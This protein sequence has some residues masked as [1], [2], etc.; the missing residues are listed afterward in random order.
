MKLNLYPPEKFIFL[1]LILLNLLLVS[2]GL[3]AQTINVPNFIPQTPEGKW[4]DRFGE[5][6]V[7]EYTGIPSIT[8][9]LHSVKLKDKDFSISLDYHAG[10]IKVTDE[11]SWVG[12]G[13]NIS[14]LGTISVE[15]VGGPDNV[16][17]FSTK[18][19]KQVA[20]DH[21]ISAGGHPRRFMGTYHVMNADGCLYDET[22]PVPNRNVIND[23]LN[24]N[25]ER[26]IYHV[27]VLGNAFKFSID[28]NTNEIIPVGEKTKFK[29]EKI[30][31]GWKMVDDV[32]YEYFFNANEYFRYNSNFNQLVNTW[33][34]TNIV[35]QG[36]ELLKTVHVS[37]SLQLLPQISDVLTKKEGSI[38]SIVRQTTYV[39]EFNAKYPKYIVTPLDSIVFIT[40][41][42]IDLRNG[43]A[44]K[45][46]RVYNRLNK[47]LIKEVDFQKSYFNGSAD[48]TDLS[49]LDYVIKRLKLDKIVVKGV[50]TE[51]KVHTFSYYDNLPYKNSFSQDFWGYYNGENNTFSGTISGIAT[52]AIHSSNRTLLPTPA[53]LLFEEDVPNTL[54]NYRAANRGVNSN[55]VKG[56]SLKNIIY[57]T[58]GSTEFDYEPN[59]VNNVT[60]VK[61]S[62]PVLQNVLTT[63][64]NNGNSTFSTPSTTFTLTKEVKGRIKVTLI[65]QTLPITN[66]ENFA[67]I[68]VTKANTSSPIIKKY[69]IMTDAQKQQFNNTKSVTIEEDVVLPPGLV[70]LSATNPGFPDQGY[71]MPNG[72]V[73]ELT[74]FNI[75]DTD[76]EYDSYVG[77]L[78]IKTLKNYGHDATILN[79]KSFEYLNEDQSSSGKLINPIRFSY[80]QNTRFQIL[81]AGSNPPIIY[82]K[83]RVDDFLYSDNLFNYSSSHAPSS[84]GYSRVVIKETDNS[85]NNGSTIKHFYNTA[86]PS[87]FSDSKKFI[88]QSLYNSALNGKL[89]KLSILNNALDTLYSEHNFYQIRNIEHRYLNISVSDLYDGPL[90]CSF[91]TPQLKDNRF[92]VIISAISSFSVQ[93]DSL[94]KTNFF[95]GLKNIL[96]KRYEYDPLNY[97]ISK[98]S[99]VHSNNQKIIEEY[100]YLLNYTPSTLTSYSEYL[101]RNM[102]GIP[103]EQTVYQNS[104]IIDYNKVA[105]STWGN[106]F[107]PQYIYR[108]DRNSNIYNYLNFLQY[109]SYGNVLEMKKQNGPSTTYLWGYN[110]QYLISK[111]EN[112]TYSD[113]LTK[114]GGVSVITQFNSSSITDSYINQKMN[115]LR[116]GLPKSLVFTYTYK[117]LVGVAS[118]TDAS[119]RIVSYEYD[120]MQRLK[121]VR[122]ENNHIVTDYKYHYKP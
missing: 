14:N 116:T 51:K 91:A 60:Y 23:V 46:L 61:S 8:I 69:Y 119:G 29:I 37:T 49:T 102:V 70:V 108:K 25:G 107:A 58:G 80:R 65:A 114:I 31:N 18:A 35:F 96:L 1:V 19:E 78:R 83:Y 55:Y 86:S 113:V 110:G 47:V 103:I 5:V 2:F 117:P 43:L 106:V 90:Q 77:G 97:K 95:G 52:N 3:S 82:F 94:Q 85:V 63:V 122:D 36:K 105:Y 64:R 99:Q 7:S 111:I 45:Y 13:W 59:Q 41:S 62:Q 101:S 20:I 71:S 44:L 89:L 120:E 28:A 79:T 57:P 39:E 84:V 72:T 38:E 118:M 11:A 4:N 53:S 73:G 66:F 42:R 30:G 24:G 40:E 92:D 75:I 121:E 10:G 104:K 17:S 56:G 76:Q 50:G 68:L 54:V 9:P 26:D 93:L 27:N 81:T 88:P 112:A 32:G 6:P 100:K 87:Y 12:L 48:G 67:V 34:L 74:Y 21:S 33:H 22:L 115:L 16:I 109:D 98:M 15:A